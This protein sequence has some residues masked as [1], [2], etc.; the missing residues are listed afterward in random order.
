M[1]E[2]CRYCAAVL[3]PPDTQELAKNRLLTGVRCHPLLFAAEDALKEIKGLRER[4][5][6]TALN[7]KPI[8]EWAELSEGIRDILN[9]Y[10]GNQ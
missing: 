5:L 1:T 9:R 7:R 10:E 3:E 8:E 2:R 4:I 6:K